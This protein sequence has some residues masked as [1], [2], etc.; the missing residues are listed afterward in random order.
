MRKIIPFEDI[1][2]HSQFP[3]M[4][5]EACFILKAFNKIKSVVFL[6]VSLYFFLSHSFKSLNF[7]YMQAYIWMCAYL[8]WIVQLQSSSESVDDLLIKK[9]GLFRWSIWRGLGTSILTPSFSLKHITHGLTSGKKNTKQ[10][11]WKFLVI[12][13]FSSSPRIAKL[14]GL[15]TLIFILCVMRL[16]SLLCLAWKT[17]FTSTIFNNELRGVRVG[18]WGENLSIKPIFMALMHTSHMPVFSSLQF[19]QLTSI[20]VDA[21]RRLLFP[22]PQKGSI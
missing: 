19:S 2:S 4:W 3:V 21:C 10:K 16:F 15:K 7:F 6:F 1:L 8:S 12:H 22:P 20:D 11:F 13:L 17:V 14:E 5:I 9:T 18:R